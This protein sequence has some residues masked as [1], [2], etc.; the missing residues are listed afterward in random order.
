MIR[1]IIYRQPGKIKDKVCQNILHETSK[2][3]MIQISDDISSIVT[4]GGLSI[5]LNSSEI[6]IELREISIGPAKMIFN[7]LT[8]NE[9]RKP[10]SF[11]AM[12]FGS[13]SGDFHIDHLKPKSKLIK[14]QK[15]YKEGD[16]IG[17]FAPI[18][19]Y[20]NVIAKMTACSDKLK[21]PN[22][23]YV[24]KPDIT[25]ID[26][27]DFLINTHARS[28]SPITNLDDQDLLAHN[29]P[30]SISDFRIKKIAK[31]LVKRI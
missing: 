13:K 29:T 4:R 6:E 10:I 25:I 16:K 9:L 20:H 17:N 27:N 24:S 2:R 11:N 21:H 14:G 12:A 1:T 23:L 30:N 22:G 26:F 19:Y 31:E 18:P 8:L 5:P 28:I 3:T 15:G 7:A